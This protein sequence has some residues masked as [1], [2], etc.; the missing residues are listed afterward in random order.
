MSSGGS[1][2]HWLGLLKG[3]DRAATQELWQ[4]YFQRL[5][6]LA[7]QKLQGRPRGA[8]DEEDVALSAFDGFCRGAEQGRFPQLED[9]N[10]LWHLLMVITARKAAR[11]ARDEA[12]QRHGATV[13]GEAAL[14]GLFGEGSDERALEQVLGSEPTPELA[15]QV[16][17]ECR[18]LLTCLGDRDLEAVAV[19]KMEGYTSAEIAAKL[20][21]VPRTVERKLHLIRSIWKQET[22]P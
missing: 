14:E 5:I 2:T 15:A 1:V 11:L 20:G 17:E 4:R 12:R 9:R 8:A 18:R 10:N 22:A 3:G 19:C 7:R 13:L 21:Y 16:A 6:G